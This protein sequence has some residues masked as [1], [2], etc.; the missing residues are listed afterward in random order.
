MG[1]SLFCDCFRGWCLSVRVITITQCTQLSDKGA[2]KVGD[3]SSED[4]RNVCP[5]KNDRFH[6]IDKR[7]R[8]W[9]TNKSH[10]LIHT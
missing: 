3:T 10:I 9:E 4:H 7:K 8:E 5:I 6:Y 2:R 1:A